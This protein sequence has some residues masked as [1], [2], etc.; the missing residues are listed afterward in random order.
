MNT[1]SKPN[2][3]QQL[4]DPRWQRK[5]LEMLEGSSWSCDECGC[6]DRTLHVHHKQYI[7][8][9]LAWE[10]SNYELAVLCEEC[11]E[12]EHASEKIMKTVLA[13][14]NTA[15]NA[16]LLGGF[17]NDADWIDQAAIEDCHE[18]DALAFAAGFVAYLVHQLDISE[19]LKVAEFAASLAGPMSEAR[20]RFK[21]RD[22]KIF[23]EEG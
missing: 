19:M 10:Y 8:G 7:K 5:R 2:Y 3:I 15:E 14:T 9:R 11:H 1:L 21:H 16:A 13:S 23:G 17:R 12:S 20:M 6:V 22:R 4:K 18:C